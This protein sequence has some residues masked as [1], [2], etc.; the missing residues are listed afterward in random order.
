MKTCVWSNPSILTRS[1]FL[2]GLGLNRSSP[3]T[4]I[5]Q[6]QGDT[7]L[8][9]VCYTEAPV[10]QVIGV[11]YTVG[12]L[13]ISTFQCKCKLGETRGTRTC[14]R[15]HIMG[16]P[17]LLLG[18]FLFSRVAKKFWITPSNPVIPKPCCLPLVFGAKKTVPETDST[19]DHVT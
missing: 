18:V 1:G 3:G 17:A 4:P 12:K 13:L 6:N 5:A 15:V 10:L 7:N 14:I 9:R 19:P 16:V 11:S 2:L 8:P